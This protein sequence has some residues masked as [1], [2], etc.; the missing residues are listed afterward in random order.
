MAVFRVQDRAGRRLD[1]IYVY[2][3]DTWGEEQ[4]AR[5]IRG[6]FERFEE[7]AARN[8]RWRPVPAEFG[9]DGFYCRYEHHYI[10]WRVLSDDTVGIVTVLHERMHQIDR[11]RE[12]LP[13]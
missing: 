10:Y 1:E 3:R 7:I 5:Y 4:A 9:V 6:L 11:F 8:I 13:Q 12:D 2:T